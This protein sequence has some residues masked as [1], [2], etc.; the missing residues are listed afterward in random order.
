MK[1]VAILAAGALVGLAPA[2]AAAQSSFA[3]AV[4]AIAQ[5]T[6]ANGMK[7]VVQEDHRV[8]LV[9]LQLR[10]EGGAA[11]EPPDRPGVAVLTTFVMLRGAKHFHAGD[12]DDLLARAG[13]TGVGHWTSTSDVRL[14][15]TVP[16]AH[17]VLPLW[18]WSDQMGFFADGPPDA[19]ITIAKN[20]LREQRS[21]AL[22]ASPVARL[23]AIAAEELYPP[24]HPARVAFVSPQ[25]VDA[26][27]RAAVVAF[28]ARWIT[29]SH[30]TLAMVGDVTAADAF[31]AAE[32]Y[33]GAIPS[34]ADEHLRIPAPVHLSGEIQVDVAADVPHAKISVHWPT[35]RTLT[36]ED[37]RL[38]V[39]AE[40]LNGTRTAWLYWKLVDEQKMAT[41]LRVQQRSGDMGSQFEITIDV[42]PGRAVAEVLAAFDAAIDEV[43]S[44][45]IVQRE[46]E[47]ATYEVIMGR[48]MA[49]ESPVT[50]AADFA[51]YTTLV[52]TPDYVRHDFDRF[53]DLSPA[54]V[55]EA[56]DKW[57]P[58]DR[59]VVLLV[60]PVHGAPPGGERRARR[61]IATRQ[62]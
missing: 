30:A 43:R 6:L 49:L 52:G 51:R 41:G 18:L 9:A 1:S 34:P 22:S 10:L 47:G 50:R 45:R 20:Q 39:V 14:W 40:L 55:H 3:E 61:F 56:I 29:P 15:A 59:R 44:R 53:R 31:A 12:Y 23:D 37:A 19:Q 24:G 11:A 60:E 2:V 57:L 26:L 21:T 35:P 33:F 46:I 25:D 8:P 54:L 4:G 62:P 27:D 16:A 58:R 13:G 17:L 7:V 48:A 38:E 32:R 5:R 42:A 28:H 36:T